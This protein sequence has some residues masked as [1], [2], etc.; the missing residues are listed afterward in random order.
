VKF[1]APMLCSDEYSRCRRKVLMDTLPYPK[2]PCGSSFVSG[3]GRMHC[4]AGTDPDMPSSGQRLRLDL[5]QREAQP[6]GVRAEVTLFA[7]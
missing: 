1:A 4:P 7:G 5:V 6:V 2:T 3:Y